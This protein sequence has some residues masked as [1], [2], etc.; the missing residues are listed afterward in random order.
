MSA[1]LVSHEAEL[2]PSFTDCHFLPVSSQGH[3]SLCLRPN[4]FLLIWKICAGIKA[5]IQPCWLKYYSIL[6]RRSA[7]ILGSLSHKAEE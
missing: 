1:S 5:S 4:L 6:A 3:P 7:R 2:C